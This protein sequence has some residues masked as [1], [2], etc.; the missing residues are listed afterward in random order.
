MVAW[1]CAVKA[2]VQLPFVTQDKLHS[3]LHKHLAEEF[4]Q[5]LGGYCGG[6]A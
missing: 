2:A 4:F 3:K 5:D 1:V 6:Q